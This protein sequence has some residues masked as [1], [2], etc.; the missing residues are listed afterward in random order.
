MVRDV[1]ASI[2]PR[3]NMSQISSVLE[4]YFGA[5]NLLIVRSSN[6]Q[7]SEHIRISHLLESDSL[8]CWAG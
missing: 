5:Q 1:R 4:P 6:A 8:T 2:D 7:S 3:T